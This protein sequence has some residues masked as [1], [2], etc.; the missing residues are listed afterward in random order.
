MN[1]DWWTLAL[2]AINVLILIWLLGHF[3]YKPV[4]AAIAARQA[5]ADKLLSDAQAAKAAAEAESAALKAQGDALAAEAGEQRKAVV[6][7]AEVSAQALLKKAE[8]EAKAHAARAEAALTQERQVAGAA[9]RQQAAELA[10]DIAGTL[11][12]RLPAAVVTEAMFQALLDKIAALPAADRQRL[13]ETA[14]TPQILTAVALSDADQARYRQRLETALG[15]PLAASFDVETALIAGF[16]LR[17]ADILVTNSWRA[18]LAA[19]LH[20][21]TG[22]SHAV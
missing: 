6:A 5:A 14:A 8:D 16:E 4:L 19:V 2:Q 7:A 9:L 21:L 13:A 20:Q 17:G 3:L 11:L 12:S 18:D 10:T 15:S 22:D 1:I